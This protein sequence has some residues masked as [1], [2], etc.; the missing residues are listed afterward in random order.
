MKI[1]T[2]KQPRVD[3]EEFS[4]SPALRKAVHERLSKLRARQLR[5]S[6]G[7]VRRA[8]ELRRKLIK[9]ARSYHGQ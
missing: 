8:R 5:E 2:T 7:L 9:E 3:L 6:K 4:G 1:S